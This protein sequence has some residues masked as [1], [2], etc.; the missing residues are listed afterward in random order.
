MCVG[1][2]LNI[3]CVC[4]GR[5]RVWNLKQI[6]CN[7]HRPIH[8]QKSH[9]FY[10]RACKGFCIVNR[11]VNV[12]NEGTENVQVKLLK[13]SNVCFCNVLFNGHQGNLQKVCFIPRSIKNCQNSINS[14]TVLIFSN[15]D[16]IFTFSLRLF[17][18]KYNLLSSYV[19]CTTLIVISIAV[20]LDVLLSRLK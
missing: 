5:K 6:H 7:G 9:T 10:S 12:R 2:L 17:L 19:I 18:Q 13:I 8:R 20:A 11:I 15:Y 4:R 14:K 3:I 16:G 1:I